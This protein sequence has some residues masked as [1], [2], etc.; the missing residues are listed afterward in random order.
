MSDIGIA[1]V[2]CGQ[3]ANVH[4]KGVSACDGASLVACVDVEPD[5]AKKAAD[6]FGAPVH[7]TDYAQVLDDPEV[8]AVVLCLPHDLH[9]PFTV[10]AA[11]A[12]KHVLVEK[13]MALT[14]SEARTMVEASDRAG[15]KLMVGQSTRF[16]PA[17]Q[18]AKELIDAGRI[19]N[20]ISVCCQRCFYVERLSTDWRR[21]ADAC[22]GIY[23]PLF[24]SHD[25]DAMLWLLDDTPDRISAAIRAASELSDGDSDG[26][27]G[28]TFAD[29]KTASI[30]FSL[31]A[32]INRQAFLAVGTEGTILVERNRLTV[33]G[34]E[35]VIDD[36]IPAFE[37]QMEWF[38]RSVAED[39]DPYVPGTDGVRT[40]R[41]LDLARAASDQRSTLT[42]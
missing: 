6:E 13:P 12:G 7:T 37:L 26:W 35:V 38:V 23:L 14:E 30:Q 3:I 41:V 25:I 39:R 27:I 32:S 36:S 31:Q 24:G 11:E 8:D 21:D 10:Q 1:M 16:M 5:R 18:K 28:M 2:G 15:K 19:G 4:M 22:G 40:M 33:D 29:G 20:P 42:F 34:E 17:F 9:L